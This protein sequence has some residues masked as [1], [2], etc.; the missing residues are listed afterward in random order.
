MAAKKKTQ[1]PEVPTEEKRTVGRPQIAIDW[2]AFDKLC[3]LQCSLLEIASFFDC[4]DDTIERAVKREKGV[5]F[6]EYFAL[7]RG[8]GKI[9]LRRAQFNLAGKDS[10]MAIWLGKQYLGQS[11]K[12]EKVAEEEVTIVDDL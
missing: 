1:T 8:K 7:K 5:H 6:A 10:R 3:Q 4:S 12:A 2:D 11:D 9:A